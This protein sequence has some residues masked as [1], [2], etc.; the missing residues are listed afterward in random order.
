MI[1][2]LRTVSKFLTAGICAVGLLACSEEMAEQENAGP[3]VDVGAAGEAGSKAEV[4]SLAGWWQHN[5]SHLSDPEEGDGPVSYFPGMRH[6]YGNERGRGIAG[7]ELWVGDYN[8]PVLQ[9][10]ATEI[11]K[12]HGDKEQEM[13]RS[14]WQMLQLCMLVGTP[15]ILLLRDP[16]EFLQEPDQVTILY[17]RDQQVRHV[18]LNEHHPEH[19]EPTPYG[20]SVGWYE[21]DTLVVDTVG[22]S[23]EGPID[24]YGTPHTEQ[25]HVIE[26]YH[27]VEDGTV[28]RVDVWAEDPGVFT[29]SWSGYQ[30][31]DRSRREDYE[32]IRCAENPK[33]V[34]GGEYPVPRDNTPDF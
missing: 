15:H 7:S 24:Y 12:A 1:A 20:H 9:P 3:A 14:G 10:W 16:V 29:T 23:V 2:R 11:V 13:G 26:R 28:L 6:L 5:V 18:Y 33:D 22:M 31:Y 30:R 32:E 17:H 8:D 34:D 27:V 4:P 19:I 21:G 25:L